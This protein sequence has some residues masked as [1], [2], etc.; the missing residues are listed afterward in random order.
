MDAHLRRCQPR[1]RLVRH[2]HRLGDQTRFINLHLFGFRLQSRITLKPSHRAT[3]RVR[4]IY[5][6]GIKGNARRRHQ[7]VAKLGRR[8]I[9]HADHIHRDPQHPP[10]CLVFE[11]QRLRQKWIQC[12]G[13]RGK[14]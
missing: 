14:P 2:T 7:L 10:P 6:D 1:D 8:M 3:V 5:H 4:S 9:R 13:T 12:G 11:H